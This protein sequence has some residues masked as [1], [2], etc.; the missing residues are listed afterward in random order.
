MRLGKFKMLTFVIATIICCVLTFITLVGAGA[1][2]EGTEGNG[3]LGAIALVLS[4][5]FYIFRFP[6]HT[7][8]F[9]FMNG[10]N[11][12]IGLFINSI[13]YGFFTERVI[14]FFKGRQISNEHHNP[15]VQ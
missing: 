15:N 10:S 11:F 5:L 7:F 12:F 6:T 3:I 4:K 8:F 1:V 2:D 9:D 13:V 14:S